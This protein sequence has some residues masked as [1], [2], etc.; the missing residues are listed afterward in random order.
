M[1]AESAIC[2]IVPSGAFSCAKPVAVNP[3]NMK[4]DMI[5]KN[6]L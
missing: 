1:S 6:R 4:N 2:G 5:R 3:N